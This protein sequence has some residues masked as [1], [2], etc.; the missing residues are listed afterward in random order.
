MKN[1]NEP[2]KT[3]AKRKNHLFRNII[4]VSGILVFIAAIASLT[5]FL[6]KNYNKNKI[7]L[8][9]IKQSWEKSDYKSKRGIRKIL[10]VA[11]AARASVADGRKNQKFFSL[12]GNNQK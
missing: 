2:S 4:I 6:V 7:T 11:A 10:K 8:T 9:T 1:K 5:V 3:F 12:T